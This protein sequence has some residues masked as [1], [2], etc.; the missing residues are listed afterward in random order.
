MASQQLL[1]A[2][3][4]VLEPRA[5]LAASGRAI[6]SAAKAR[7]EVDV[8]EAA[9]SGRR[10]VRRHVRQGGGAEAA[11]GVAGRGLDE[12][13]FERALAE[14]PSVG[15]AVEGHPARQA[16]VRAGRSAV[17]VGDLREQDLLQHHLEAAR[18]VLGEGA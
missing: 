14:D 7:P 3:A 10:P 17:E 8:A 5:A 18:D 1:L 13:A 16:E 12:Q 2:A 9:P 15:H 6:S 4:E 11:A